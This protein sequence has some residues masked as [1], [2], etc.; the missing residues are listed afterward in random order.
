MHIYDEGWAEAELRENKAIIN[1][2]DKSSLGLVQATA[3]VEKR[4]QK[5]DISLLLQLQSACTANLHNNTYT[6]LTFKELNLGFF[7][8]LLNSINSTG[9]SLKTKRENSY[10]SF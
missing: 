4:P 7:T 3:L 6:V 2:A 5:E 9:S 8:M 1:M 10:E